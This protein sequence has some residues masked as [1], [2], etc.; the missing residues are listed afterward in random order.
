MLTSPTNML[1]YEHV[2][3]C[4]CTPCIEQLAHTSSQLSGVRPGT[5]LACQPAG[6]GKAVICQQ[7]PLLAAAGDLVTD[8]PQGHTCSAQYHVVPLPCR[9]AVAQHNTARCYVKK[10]DKGMAEFPGVEP[11]VQETAAVQVGYWA[12]SS[13][14][15]PARMTVMQ[16]RRRPSRTQPAATGGSHGCSSLL[17]APSPYFLSRG[18]MLTGCLGNIHHPI[19]HT[20]LL[21][22]VQEHSGV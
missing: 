3:S 22:V 6:A 7:A 16:G 21:L 9:D 8:E 18:K 5:L 1:S 11:H 4:R 17:A 10:R 14:L 13:R 19:N 15:I 2:G 12:C 20:G